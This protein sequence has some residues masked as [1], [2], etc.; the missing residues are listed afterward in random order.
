MLG[1]AEL[2]EP[3]DE[4]CLAYAA[5]W[6]A[7][8]LNRSPAEGRGASPPVTEGSRLKSGR[9]DKCDFNSLLTWETRFSLS[10]YSLNFCSDNE[11][12]SF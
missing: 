9:F 1:D 3:N 10:L 11:S 4:G 5:A 6:A 8:M 12:K 7:A 2:V